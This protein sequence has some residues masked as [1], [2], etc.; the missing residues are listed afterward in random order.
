MAWPAPIWAGCCSSALPSHF[1]SHRPLPGFEGIDAG[2]ANNGFRAD[3]HPKNFG[4]GESGLKSRQKEFHGSGTSNIPADAMDSDVII[5]Q[6]GNSSSS[7]QP[8]PNS[9][10]AGT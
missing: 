4:K 9:K 2:Q 3:G 1:S 6:V 7:D 5:R 8:R 10:P